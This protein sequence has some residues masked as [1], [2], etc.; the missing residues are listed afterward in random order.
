MKKLL[1]I[2]GIVLLVLLIPVFFLIKSKGKK[3]Q[4]PVEEAS[5]QTLIE[6]PLEERP[7]V[8]LT[9]TSDGKKLIMSVSRIKNAQKIEYELTYLS[10]G[11]SRGV[12]GSVDAS[13]LE[14]KSRELLL[15]SCSKNTCV[16]DV[17]V[18]QGTL[19]LRFRDG[20][21]VRKFSSD[22]VLKQ[23]VDKLVSSDGK[24][25]F[26][27]KAMPKSFYI[28]MSTIGL[29][30]DVTGKVVSAPYGV[31]AESSKSVIGATVTISL[32]EQDS[33]AKL[34]FWNSEKW[35]NEEKGLKIVE[36]TISASV[37]ALGTF[38]VTAP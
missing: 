32:D 3:V 21:A 35:V 37:D 31:F 7:F 38:V 1:L 9:P 10:Q 34:F 12:I 16:Y 24:F 17:G 25:T 28:V 6:T 11:L 14:N 23:G 18:E 36:K 19:T 8:T 20:T 4:T 26:E 27:K 2:V 29:P 30:S 15:G 5:T 22:F 13:E 33:Q